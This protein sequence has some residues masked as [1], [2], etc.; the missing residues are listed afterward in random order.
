MARLLIQLDA[1]RHIDGALCVGAAKGLDPRGVSF[2]V[3]LEQEAVAV[4]LR[5]VGL[6]S[7]CHQRA[8]EHPS[9]VKCTRRVSLG[10]GV[11]P[12]LTATDELGDLAAV[13]VA[14]AGLLEHKWLEVRPLWPGLGAWLGGGLL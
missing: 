13:L 12:T 8:R 14:L 11:D 2:G 3:Q 6:I 7:R 5:G 1:L 9:D 4:S 10:D